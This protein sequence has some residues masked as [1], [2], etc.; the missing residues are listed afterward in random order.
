MYLWCNSNKCLCW[1]DR[2]AE[3]TDAP[4]MELGV[5]MNVSGMLGGILFII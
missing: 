3:N 2:A 4:G 1:A 5:G